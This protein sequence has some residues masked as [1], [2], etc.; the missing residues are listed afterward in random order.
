MNK[1]E[2]VS[3]CLDQGFTCSQVIPLTYGPELGLD[4]E[5]ALKI[6]AAL[7]A[8]MSRTGSICGAVSSAVLVLSL[9]HGHSK[10]GDKQGRENIYSLVKDYINEFTTLHGSVNCTDLLGYDISTADGL[11]Q[12]R[13]KSIFA[14][15][16]PK[17]IID[18]AKIMEQFL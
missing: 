16:C 17:F 4:C 5:T 10:A 15:I 9:R 18:A 8:G 1:V 6:S 11:T 7:G 2:K 14:S 13:E 12:A 3:S